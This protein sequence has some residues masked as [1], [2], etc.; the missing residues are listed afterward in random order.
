MASENTVLVLGGSGKTGRRVVERLNARNVPVRIGSRSAEHPF[1][2]NQPATW[3]TVLQGI[4]SVYITYQPDLAVPGAVEAID[5]FTK[6]AMAANVQRLVLLSGR[7]EDEAQRCEQV[8]QR[9]GADW[10]LLRSSWFAQNF[11]E[12]FL[13]EPILSGELMLPVGDIP[14]PFIDAEDIAD[15]A[16]AALTESSH[17]GQIYELTG[18]RLLAFDQAVAEIAEAT[19]RDIRLVQVSPEQY[20]AELRTAGVPEGYVWLMSY[21]FT[22]VMDGRNASLSDGVQRAI[23]RAPSDFSDYARRTAVTG[24]WAAAAEQQAQSPLILG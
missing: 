24:V 1:D 4:H 3:G 10:T 7:G 23:G 14:E 11:S 15:V 21:L 6:Q 9:A 13:L 8:I 12:N 20:T 16:V 18:P 19:G 22:T 17:S 2:W 5:A